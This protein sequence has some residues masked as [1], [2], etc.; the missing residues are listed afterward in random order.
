VSTKSLISTQVQPVGFAAKPRRCGK[1]FGFDNFG[2]DDQCVEIRA[3]SAQLPGADPNTMASAVAQPL[4]RQFAQIPGV[5]Q[6]TSASVL[7]ATNITL[8]FDLSRNIDGAAGDV[9]QAINAAQGYLPKNLPTPPT[10]KKVNP[11][12]QP[13]LI[14]GLTSEAMPLTQLDQFAD[15]DV[16]QQ[17]STLSGVGQ[18]TIFGEQKYAPTIMINPLSLASRGIGKSSC[19]YAPG[20]EPIL[21]DRHQWADLP[22]RAARQ[23]DCYISQR[24]AGATR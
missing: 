20:A 18:V 14:L 5:N 7:G 2:E 3:V 12:D 9:Q 16:A 11:A 21:S 13:V 10:Y 17:I 22:P 23:G 24:R 8:Q 19:W 6:I 1:T 4:E 15:L